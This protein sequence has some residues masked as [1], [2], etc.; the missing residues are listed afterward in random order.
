MT[1]YRNALLQ[2]II[3][4]MMQWIAFSDICLILDN[5]HVH[6]AHQTKFTHHN[7]TSNACSVSHLITFRPSPSKLFVFYVWT[8]GNFWKCLLINMDYKNNQ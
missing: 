5:H 7:G 6:D 1:A 8:F 2:I 4:T 3:Q